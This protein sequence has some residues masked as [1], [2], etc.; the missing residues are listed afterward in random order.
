MVDHNKVF[1]LTE[2]EKWIC[3]V[4]WLNELYSGY[5]YLQTGEMNL[6]EFLDEINPCTNECP[7]YKK[8]PS[9]SHDPYRPTVPIPKNF[10]VLERF[11]GKYSVVSPM[12]PLK[13]NRHKDNVYRHE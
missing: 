11:T 2:Q 6:E 12:F 7:C 9:T 1:E 5:Y 3:T 4:R 10:R 13:D 8:C